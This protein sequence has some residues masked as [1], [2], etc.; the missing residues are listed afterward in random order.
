M[1]NVFLSLMIESHQPR[2]IIRIFTLLRIPGI[3]TLMNHY[4][5]WCGVVWCGV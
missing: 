2:R 4:T 5:V 1:E 3:A